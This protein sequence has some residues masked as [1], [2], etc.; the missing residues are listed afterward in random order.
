MFKKQKDVF[1]HMNL[2]KTWVIVNY[3]GAKICLPDHVNHGPAS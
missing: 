1:G 3:F 2:P